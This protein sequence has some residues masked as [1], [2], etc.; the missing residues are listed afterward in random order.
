MI[1]RNYYIYQYL[2]MVRDHNR[3]KMTNSQSKSCMFCMYCD[4]EKY[5]P[6]LNAVIKMMIMIIIIIND[7]NTIKGENRRGYHLKLI[8]EWSTRQEQ[9]FLISGRLKHR[10]SCFDDYLSVGNMEF[11]SVATAIPTTKSPF[12]TTDSLHYPVKQ[13]IQYKL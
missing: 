12:L 3:R 10:N 9:Y 8:L 13:L 2:G 6:L 11:E 4:K 5:N 7:D 1:N